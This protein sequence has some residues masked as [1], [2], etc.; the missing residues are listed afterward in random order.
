MNVL[1]PS[2]SKFEEKK[3]VQADK[4]KQTIKTIFG[5]TATL[6]GKTNFDNELT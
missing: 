2:F 6:S 5:K 1:P 3:K 4:K